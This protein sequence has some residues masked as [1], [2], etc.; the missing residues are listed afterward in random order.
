MGKHITVLKQETVDS[1]N[2]KAGGI[3]VDATLGNGGHSMN[4]LQTGLAL[5]L[6]T[7][8][9][10]TNAIAGFDQQLT[11]SG[12]VKQGNQ[13]VKGEQKVI[14]VQ[15]NF[16]TLKKLLSSLKINNID[17]VIADLGWSTDQIETLP[18]LSYSQNTA[19]DMRFDNSLAVTAAD[20]LNALGLRE[21]EQMF[22]KFADLRG[23]LVRQLSQHIIDQ[24]KVSAFATT[25]QLVEVIT[26]LT[27]DQRD[28]AQV[29]QALRIGVNSELTNLKDLLEQG[30]TMLNVG[31][32]LGVIT[33]HSKEEDVVFSFAKESGFGMPEA[34]RPTVAEL[35][36]NLK[37]R[38]GKLWVLT[39]K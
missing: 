39:K 29:F 12:F 3:Y 16:A 5:T 9:L 24:R 22:Y 13:Y 25:T 32:K 19:L 36:D 11:T 37:A 28:V 38:S 26:A 27:S 15:G 2:L 7:I 18:G 10:D 20:L 1:L 34:I 30:Y 8:D 35:R 14:V 31:G 6:I 23:A 21:L 17:G 33:F 4:I